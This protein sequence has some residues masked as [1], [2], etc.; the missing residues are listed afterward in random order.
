MGPMAGSLMSL[1]RAP[2]DVAC[3]SGRVRTA[4]RRRLAVVDRTSMTHRRTSVLVVVCRVEDNGRHRRGNQVA[5]TAVTPPV[6]RGVAM[7]RLAGVT[8]V[9]PSCRRTVHGVAAAGVASQRRVVVSRVPRAVGRVTTV[10]RAVETPAAMRAERVVV[11]RQGASHVVVRP[12]AIAD[13]GRRAVGPPEDCC[14]RWAERLL[15]AGRQL[16]MP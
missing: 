1:V 9:G 11:T 7:R 15:L 6:S 10:V 8:V 2:A 3:E 12:R 13:V 5:G 4:L 16:A 14:W